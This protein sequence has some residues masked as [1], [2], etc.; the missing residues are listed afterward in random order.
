MN[1]TQ[2]KFLAIIAMTCN[3]IVDAFHPRLTMF[4]Q[5]MWAIGMLTAPAMMY[6]LAEGWDRTS[7]RL[8]YFKRLALFALVSQLPFM[9]VFHT[10]TIN[11]IGTLTLTMILWF[12]FEYTQ[13]ALTKLKDLMHKIEY[14]QFSKFSKQDMKRINQQLTY[15]LNNAIYQLMI[16]FLLMIC[17]TI[18]FYFCDGQWIAF[19]YA[20]IFGLCKKFYPSIQFTLAALSFMVFAIYLSM[21]PPALTQLSVSVIISIGLII[22]LMYNHTQANRPFKQFFYLYYPSHLLIFAIFQQFLQK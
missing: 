16:G 11:F 12:G 2:L 4:W 17:S 21:Y 6:L 14:T 20:C 5:V 22:Q 9:L 7:N 19:M 15:Y 3:H 8:N 18:L 13:K 1:R 10:K